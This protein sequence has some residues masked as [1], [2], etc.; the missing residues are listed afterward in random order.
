M[1]DTFPRY[2]SLGMATRP[3]ASGILLPSSIN[4]GTGWYWVQIPF[5]TVYSDP[6]AGTPNAFDP[7]DPW[8]CLR[9][10]CAVS[11][12]AWVRL[13][14]ALPGASIHLRPFNLN[15]AGVRVGSFE[16]VE[17]PVMQGETGNT[18]IFGPWNMWVGAGNRLQFELDHW[19][20]NNTTKIVGAK[21][22]ALY[23]RP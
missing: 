22:T 14:G 6:D 17:E 8:S 9:G 19:H 21:V 7:T 3:T 2:L 15:P 16:S 4:T 13:I 10:S 1:A 18:H 5:D 11:V 20:G 23:W 12:T